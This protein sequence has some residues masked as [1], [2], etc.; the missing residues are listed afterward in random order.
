[1]SAGVRAHSGFLEHFRYGRTDAAKIRRLAAEHLGGAAV[2]GAVTTEARFYL[3]AKRTPAPSEPAQVQK[4]LTAIA[5]TCALL[6]E[7]LQ[8]LTAEARGILWAQAH[9]ER[10][11]ELLG[12]VDR[13]AA[14]AFVV[15]DLVEQ[16][17]QRL[18]SERDGT[19]YRPRDADRS[20]RNR[21]TQIWVDHGGPLLP[22]SRNLEK[23][24]EPFRG[25]LSDF[26]RACMEPVVNGHDLENLFE[27]LRRA[28]IKR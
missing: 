12:L 24:G 11:P 16:A 1:V 6:V 27:Q 3:L 22:F 13:L 5:T 21:L 14:D 15:G 23:S 8:G 10:A 19:R 25:P 17:G 26:L 28:R 18:A 20:L 7:R 9:A 2:L 4:E